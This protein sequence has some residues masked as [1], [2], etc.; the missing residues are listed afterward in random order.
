[1]SATPS[2]GGT[3]IP[4]AATDDVDGRTPRRRGRLSL[5]PAARGQVVVAVVASL[6]SFFAH[7]RPW[8]GG[9]VEEW[10]LALAWEQNGFAQYF[11][12]GMLETTMARPLLLFPVYLV[13]EISRGSMVG[14]Y[15]A[16]ALLAVAQ[17][18]LA[19]WALR[20]TGASN[21]VR[22]MLGL[23]LALHPWWI[24]GY[25]IRFFSAQVAITLC[26]VWFGATV[27]YVKGGRLS[28]AITGAVALLLGCLT[29]PAPG[30]TVF[31][32]LAALLVVSDVSLRR[33]VV[34]SVTTAGA[35]GAYG[36]WSLV[37]APRI[38]TTYESQIMEYYDATPRLAV[39]SILRTIA[40]HA[41]GLLMLMALTAVVILA[42]G[43]GQI[44]SQARAWLTLVLLGGTV[45]A[46]LV[47]YPS[48]FH[49]TSAEHVPSVVG[50]SAW[51]ILCALAA[52]IDRVPRLSLG[53]QVITVVSV[54][55]AAVAGHV[56][57][58]RY[59]EAQQS[60]LEQAETAREE[61]PEGE[62][63]VVADASGY[64]GSLYMLL[65]PYVD[66]ALQVE[67]GPGPEAVL[68]TVAGVAKQ[69]GVDTPDCTPLVDVP[70][71]TV[72]SR[73]E[74]PYGEVTFYAVPD[75]GTS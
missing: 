3:V 1:M 34:A 4:S 5:R 50:L 19:R 60:L 70:D 39:T 74:T 32:G 49:L 51:F 14:L 44:L 53:L 63:L 62:R 56:V 67:D 16:A 58:G 42:L 10:G 28:W 36:V 40:L 35:V 75:D 12:R 41:P 20:P 61:V 57:W 30:L 7:F 69:S 45:G 43:F 27:R 33:A 37:V 46:A 71:A 55:V 2:V 26:V 24:S 52:R 54:T 21:G 48:L 59:A 18:H 17:L 72:I 22:W 9:L 47:Y 25:A 6:V 8:Q 11:D 66:I 64:Y 68:C 29:Y 15:A 23:A 65:T 31:F 73:G 38:A 13:L